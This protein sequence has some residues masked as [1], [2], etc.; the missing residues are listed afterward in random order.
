MMTNWTLRGACLSWAL[1]LTLAACGDDAGI[2]SPDVGGRCAG[3]VDCATDSY[4][5]SGSDFPDGM[6]TRSC[7]NI[8]DCPVGSSCMSKEGG[9]CMLECGADADCRGGYK[10]KDQDRREGGKALVCK[11]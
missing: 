8:D 2:D 11:K 3:N 10:C 7:G 5:E 1:M 4:C 9:I 6:C